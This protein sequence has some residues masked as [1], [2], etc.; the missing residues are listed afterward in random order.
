MTA[1]DFANRY[2]IMSKEDRY[3]RDIQQLEVEMTQF[4][5]ELQKLQGIIDIEKTCN[6]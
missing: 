3:R 1:I 5:S 2:E 6:V 4:V